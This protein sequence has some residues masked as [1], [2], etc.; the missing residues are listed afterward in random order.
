VGG[1]TQHI[2]AYQIEANGKTVTFL[3]TPGH[4]AF[5]AMRAR[6]AQ[7]TDIAVLVV[8][9]DDGVQPQTREAVSHA[10]AAHV[11]IIVAINKIDLATANQDL[12]KQQLAEMGL[13]PEEWGGET[14]FVPVSARTKQG[15]PALLDMILLVAEMAEYKANPRANAEGTVI[16]GKIDRS[17]GPTAT[18]LVEEGVLKPGDT[19]LV[20]ET[21]GKIRAMFDH[22][23]KPL[24]RATPAT[25]VVVMGLDS[26]PKAGD[27]FNRVE[28][29]K[30][31]REAVEK[32]HAEQTI[33]QTQPVAPLTLEQ[34]YAQA[35]AGQVQTLNLIL[36]ADVQ[37]SLEPIKNSLDKLDV[38][39]LKVRFIHDGVGTIGESDVMLAIASNAIIVGF[40]VAVDPAVA[41]MPEAAKVSIRTYDVIYRLI[42]D[43]QLA[44]QGMLAPE[45]HDVVAGRAVVRSIF[46]IPKV[47]VIAGVQISEGKALRSSTARVLRGKDK[48]F[49]GQVG[50][51]KRFTE[52]VR[53]VTI[54][55][56]CG[57]GLDGFGDFQA[58]DVI[59]FYVKER[60]K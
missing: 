9:A 53:E 14:I 37:G 60:V 24:K 35:Q 27:R 50:S 40:S 17:R 47:G 26:V 58:D 23:G 13:V 52:D 21:Y 8:A 12:V 6:G 25:P 2:G 31:A 16:E 43:V 32:L 49:E 20:G 34:V 1:I 29:E 55:M 39:E 4:E 44:L 54:G 46:R 38:G 22:R 51:L 18:L 7:V 59:E 10:R 56:E 15:I 11:P 45:Y 28:S 41:H 48:L 57:V 30:V 19:I 5:T 33:V 3:D 42:E 36:K